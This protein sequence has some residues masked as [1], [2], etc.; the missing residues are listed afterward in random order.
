MAPI[1]I[2]EGKVFIARQSG[3]NVAAAL[4]EA[5]AKV[6]GD[7]HLDVRSTMNGYHVTKEVA[8]QYQADLPEVED[9]EVEDDG[10]EEE[11]EGDRLA[12]LDGDVIE[13][14]PGTEGN[15]PIEIE[16]QP[17]APAQVVLAD[18]STP[19]VDEDG[20]P[21]LPLVEDE[22]PEP[23]PVSADNTHDEIDAYAGKLTPPVTFPTNTN[24]ADKIALLEAAR[25]PKNDDAE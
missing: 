23:L 11:L 14:I 12:G 16:G 25:A 21:I 13:T 8:E 2:P 19:E 6:G 10:T 18:G 24:K 3:V 1:R 17:I 5:V 4:F 20:N 7:R 9:D 15:E 22:E